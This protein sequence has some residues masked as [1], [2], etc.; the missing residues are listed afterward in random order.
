MCVNC[1]RCEIHRR[2]RRRRSRKSQSPR[3]DTKQNVGSSIRVFNVRERAGLCAPP[4]PPRATC[5][6]FFVLRWYVGFGRV[7]PLCFACRAVRRALLCT[8]TQRYIHRTQTRRAQVD[9]R[10]TLPLSRSNANANTTQH[11]RS[12]FTR[13]TTATLCFIVRCVCVCAGHGVDSR[14]SFSFYAAGSGFSAV[15]SGLDNLARMPNDEKC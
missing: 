12:R 15:F 14:G 9:L 3:N 10:S 4:T 11:A 8:L 13:T 2:R 1:T 5:V 6:F 7:S